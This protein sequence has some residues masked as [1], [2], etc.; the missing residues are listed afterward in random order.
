MNRTSCQT[1]ISKVRTKGDDIEATGDWG[2]AALSEALQESPA[3]G[4]EI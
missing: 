1:E 3:K 4:E 2:M